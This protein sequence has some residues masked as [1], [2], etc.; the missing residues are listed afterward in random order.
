MLLGKGATPTHVTEAGPAEIRT[1][2]RAFNQMSADLSHAD[3]DRVV[4]ALAQ[5][6]N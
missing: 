6:L 2:A 5:A 3:Q 4:A 1:L